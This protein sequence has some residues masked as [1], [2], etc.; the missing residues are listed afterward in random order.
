MDIKLGHVCARLGS[1]LRKLRREAHISQGSLSLSAGVSVGTI[2]AIERGSGTLK[3]WVPVLDALGCKLIA[4]HTPCDELV[5]SLVAMRRRHGFSARD[6]AK[7]LGVSR[8]TIAEMERGGDS[9]IFTVSKYAAAIGVGLSIVSKDH[10][11]RFYAAAGNA[12]IF[13]GWH[14]P[15]SLFHAIERVVGTFDL[16]PC[17]PDDGAGPVVARMKFCAAED[18]LIRE[19][20]GKVFMNPPYGPTIRL[21]TEK[22]KSAAGTGCQVVGLLP[23]RT[24][25]LW[26]HRD[27][28]GIANIIFLKGRL[29]FGDGKKPAPFPSA[30]VLW[31]FDESVALAV[32]KAVN[33]RAV[34]S[35]RG[36]YTAQRQ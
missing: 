21:W 3:T 2:K 11:P 25:T 27:V 9:R 12:S 16:D 33:G 6:M 23:A 19:W 14:T 34:L 24:D 32:A 22:A 1:D 26:W 29:A 4:R 18:G 31:G 10:T 7:R 30:L 8:S 35:Q 36:H 15:P 20:W 5:S 28:M 17:A 13:H